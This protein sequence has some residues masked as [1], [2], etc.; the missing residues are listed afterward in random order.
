MN[1]KLA[2]PVALRTFLV[3]RTVRRSF[4]TPGTIGKQTL[5]SLLNSQPTIIEIGT[6]VGTDT[7]QLAHAFPKGKI[8]G[9]EPHPHLFSK[10][11]KSV[12]KFK[13]V[14]LIPA[15]LSNVSGFQ[16]FRQSSGTSDGS[17]SLL[18]ASNHFPYP[19]VHFL[20]QDEVIV[21]VSTLDKFLEKA[22]ITNVDLIWIDAQGPEGLV[23]DGAA[24]TLKLTQ[25]VYCEVATV[26]EYEGASPYSLIKSTLAQ[27][28]LHPIKEF[29]PTSWHG[30]GNVLFGR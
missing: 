29:M 25:Y 12:K 10:A 14:T 21:A 5:L 13:N 1:L 23:F 22:L 18:K 30:S 16:I 19:T 8:F 3:P 15:A 20:E 26:P 28:N 17:G 27:Y 7:Q 9:F 11:T 2:M 6:H 24:R 4:D